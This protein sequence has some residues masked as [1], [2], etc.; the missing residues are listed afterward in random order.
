MPIKIEDKEGVE[1]EIPT[2][3]ELDALSEK[4]KQA[5]ELQ[6]KVKELEENV[7][8]R[9]KEARDKMDSLEKSNKNLREKMETAG[10]KQETSNASI[11]DTERI[12]EAQVRKGILADYKDD[13]LSNFGDKRS[14][15]ES[16]YNTFASSPNSKIETKEDVR[17]FIQAAGRAAGLTEEQNPINTMMSHGGQSAPQFKD[18]TA[19][20]KDW[21]RSTE[22]ESFL[23]NLGLGDVID[24]EPKK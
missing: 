2:K 10:I 15:V 21:A 22:G 20:K 12:A 16:F 7:N 13:M 1:H 3:E 23:R 4:A 5:D 14:D 19:E 9:W 24:K 8:P 6:T 18:K 17:K 11:E